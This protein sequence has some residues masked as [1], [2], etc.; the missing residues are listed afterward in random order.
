MGTRV[1]RP[2]AWSPTCARWAS[3]RKPRRW[4]RST[5]WLTIKQRPA[6]HMKLP[7]STVLRR[8]VAAEKALRVGCGS[9]EQ[10]GKIVMRVAARPSG[11]E[12]R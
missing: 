11:T 10:E 12:R 7:H 6:E 8:C 4:L 5:G 2:G 3:G 1:E 9:G